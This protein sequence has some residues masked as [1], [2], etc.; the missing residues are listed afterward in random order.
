MSVL[1]AAHFACSDKV[2][3]S[4]SCHCSDNVGIEWNRVNMG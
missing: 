4:A 3:C 2:A 1:V